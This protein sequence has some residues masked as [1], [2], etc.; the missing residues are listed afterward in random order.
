MV[1]R[2][3]SHSMA[4]SSRA[5][6]RQADDLLRGERIGSGA[7]QL[8]GL[9]VE[10]GQGGRVDADADAAAG[11]DLSRQDDLLAQGDLPAPVDGPVDLHGAW[12][13]GGVQWERRR[14]SRSAV[15]PQLTR[16]D[17]RVDR[18][19]RFFEEERAENHAPKAVGTDTVP[20]S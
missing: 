6:A 14:A 18:I 13:P 8:S 1:R 2:P 9:G 17:L 16:E 15:L 7:Q 4:R 19:A 10:E 3:S 5:D 12:T 11:E 20:R